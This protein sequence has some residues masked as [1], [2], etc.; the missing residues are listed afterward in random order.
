MKISGNART[1]TSE[2][3]TC[4]LR[5]LQRT[6]KEMH[7]FKSSISGAVETRKG[8]S[9]RNVDDVKR[10]RKYRGANSLIRKK[11]HRKFMEM[12]TN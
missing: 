9:K 5:R 12:Q 3:D 8:N 7:I 6:Q 2:Y 11:C 4:E 1:E 10:G